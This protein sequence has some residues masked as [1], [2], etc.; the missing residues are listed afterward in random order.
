MNNAVLDNI[1]SEFEKTA[2]ERHIRVHSFQEGRGMSG[3]KGLHNKVV[4]DASSR[5]GITGIETVE[6]I[7]ADHRQM[8]R[9]SSR[10]DPQYRAVLGVLKQF[11]HSRQPSIERIADTATDNGS[12]PPRFE[13]KTKESPPSKSLRKSLHYRCK[14]YSH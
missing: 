8:V 3:I 5:L 4:D 2:R 1:Q 14:I 7:D 11:L 12:I 10:S 6:T 9:C 13:T